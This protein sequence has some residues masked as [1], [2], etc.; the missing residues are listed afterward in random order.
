MADRFPLIVNSTSRK[1]EELV[2][3]DNLELTGNGLII[4]GD[5]GAGKYLTSDGTQVLW[6]TP[7]DVYLT[8]TQTVTNKT[9]ENCTLSG[10]LNSISNLPNTALVNSGINI[11]GVSVALGGSVT[12]PD[13]NTTYSI[14]AADGAIASEKVIR[15]SDA[16]SGIDDVTLIAGSNM[17]INRSGDELTFISSFVDTDTV[18]TLAAQ[19]GGTAQS[20]A[21]IIKMRY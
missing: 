18:T 14:S 13:N 8:Q 12:T 3:G 19:T 15:L 5:T 21:M 6:D 20:G 17:T 1:I 10:T 9:F 2:S 16:A 4:S 11:N 7:G